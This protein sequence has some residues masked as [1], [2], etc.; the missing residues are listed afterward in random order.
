MTDDR[1]W[2]DKTLGQYTIGIAYP[3]PDGPD[4]GHEPRLFGFAPLEGVIEA[5]LSGIDDP[6]FAP[7][8]AR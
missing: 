5:A 1:E 6:A 3:D 8:H 2:N 7:H 4:A